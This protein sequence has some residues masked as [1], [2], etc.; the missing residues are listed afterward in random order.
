MAGL[1]EGRMLHPLVVDG[2][3]DALSLSSG[4]GKVNR[5][6]PHC[7]EHGLAVQ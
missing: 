1:G 6:D 5:H 7:L 2:G 4:T 3:G